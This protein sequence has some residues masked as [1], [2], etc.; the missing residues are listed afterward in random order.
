MAL[1]LTKD[2]PWP[3]TVVLAL[4]PRSRAYTTLL[5]LIRERETSKQMCHGVVWAYFLYVLKILRQSQL[6]KYCD[7]KPEIL[8]KCDVVHYGFI[9][10]S[11]QVYERY[12]YS[13]KNDYIVGFYFR[14]TKWWRM[15]IKHIFQW[16]I[17]LWEYNFYRNCWQITY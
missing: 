12:S 1:L 7:R 15:T 2:S 4:G 11:D 14:L 13:C 8:N 6:L 5:G 3:R 16:R 9:L 10:M 17:S